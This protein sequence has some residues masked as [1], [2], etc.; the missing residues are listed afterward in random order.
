MT[1]SPRSASPCGALDLLGNVWEWT[2]SAI[3]EGE[4]LQVVKG[5]CYSDPVTI[6]RADLRLEAG[7]KDK[8]EN[9]GFRCVKNA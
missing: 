3:A 4:G 5:G 9:I 8:F 1:A 7:A 2:A 6:L